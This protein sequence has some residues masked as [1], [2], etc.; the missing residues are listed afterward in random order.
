MI[1]GDQDQT[2]NGI[3]EKYCYNNDPVNCTLYGGLYHWD[4]MMMYTTQEGTQGIC[5]TGWHLPT[6]E[7]WKVLEGAVDSLFGIGD[8]EWDIFSNLRGYDAGKNLKAK[9]NWAG[10]GNGADLFGF[11]GLPGGYRGGFNY[12]D[13]L[14]V[15]GYWWTSTEIDNILAWD[16]TLDNISSEVFR[17]QDYQGVSFSVRCLRNK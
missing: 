2:N 12:F 7:E 6:D 5:P 3:K 8:N 10:N 15:Y 11:S 1:N 16:H 14:N 4:E 17:A 9:S 13:Y